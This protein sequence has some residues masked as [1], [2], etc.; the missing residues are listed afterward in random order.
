MSSSSKTQGKPARQPEKPKKVGLAPRWI[1]DEGLLLI[2]GWARDGLTDLDVAHNIGIHPT[3]LYDW[4]KKYPQ[5]AE[6]LTNGKDVADRRVENALYKRA[7]GY[8]YDEVKTT[9]QT[10]DGK[11]TKEAV[12]TK[13]RKHVSG[14]VTAQIYWLK[15]RK[16]KTWR[17]DEGRQNGTGA[18]VE[19]LTP[20]AEML[21]LKD[22]E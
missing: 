21:R 18:S 16:P 2:E 10:R 7:T 22:G 11:P 13:T 19:D 17:L 15:N 8:D 20:L 6:A 4:K 9:V 12:V 3:T 14:D 5:I 1:T